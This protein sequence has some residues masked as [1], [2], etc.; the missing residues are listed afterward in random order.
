MVHIDDLVRYW[1]LVYSRHFFD[2]F[3]SQIT[4]QIELIRLS[5]ASGFDKKM[6]SEDARQSLRYAFFLRYYASFESHLKAICERFAKAESLSLR[7]SDISGDNFLSKV[8]KY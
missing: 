7:V 5:P 8:N 1:R 4:S 3:E 2:L 6:W